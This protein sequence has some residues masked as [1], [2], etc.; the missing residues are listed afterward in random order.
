MENDQQQPPNDPP[1]TAPS[2]RDTVAEASRYL[3]ERREDLVGQIGEIEKFLGFADHAEDLAA[4][5][6]KIENFLGLNKG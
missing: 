4:R 3:K 6:A 1:N 5:V 2:I